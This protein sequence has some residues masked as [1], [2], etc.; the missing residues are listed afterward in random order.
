MKRFI[1]GIILLSIVFSGCAIVKPYESTNINI[2][3]KYVCSNDYID[4]DDHFKEFP[5]DIPTINFY[6]EGGCELTINYLEGV[7]VAAGAYSVEGNKLVIKINFEGTIFEGTG[8]EYMNEQYVFDIIHDDK[9][10]TQE[11]FS[12]ARSGDA[13]LKVSDTP[14]YRIFG[15]YICASDYFADFICEDKS[16]I[17]FN[18]NRSC[19]FRISNGEGTFS[20]WGIYRVDENQIS[21]DLNVSGTGLEETGDERMDSQYGFSILNEEKIAIDKRLYVVNNGDFFIKS[22]V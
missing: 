9:I 3:G 4:N 12:V 20:A 17:I 8:A 18:R 7:C 16:S 1:P 6:Q 15:E 5:E 19:E 10:I 13:F 11:D 21:V 22:N 14:D 2:M